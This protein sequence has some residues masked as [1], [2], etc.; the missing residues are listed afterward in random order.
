MPFSL[1]S[2]EKFSTKIYFRQLLRKTSN[3]EYLTELNIQPINRPWGLK[4]KEIKLIIKNYSNNE[5]V[6][7]W[8]LGLFLRKLGFIFLI[9]SPLFIIIEMIIE[10]VCI[11]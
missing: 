9:L 3:S 5:N 7:N 4:M 8:K 6:K 11:G 1:F 2:K 10:K